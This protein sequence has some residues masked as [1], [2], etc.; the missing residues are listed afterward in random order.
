MFS[1]NDLLNVLLKLALPVGGLSF[2]MVWWALRGGVLSSQE[3]VRALS[4]EIDALSKAR[5]KDRK[6]KKKPAKV[7]PV[8]D[9]WLKFGGGFYGI[10][11]LYTY[12]LI[13]FREIRETIAGLGG[14]REFIGSLSINLLINMIIEGLMN[15]IA[16]ISWPL[17]WMSEFGSG[18]IWIWM[19]IAYGAYWLGIRAAQHFINKE[20]S[21]DQDIGSDD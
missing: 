16:A 3:S 19:V 1:S 13:E 18:Q 12:G 21:D 20:Q 4:K 5:K 17:Y 11:A 14:I 15:F 10:V 9:K 7:N 8:H 2:L 6:E